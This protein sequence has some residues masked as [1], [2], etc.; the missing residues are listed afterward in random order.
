M[1]VLDQNPYT[2]PVVGNG[3]NKSYN[4]AFR[5]DYLTD[6]R[7]RVRKISDNTVTYY[8]TDFSATGLTVNG[9]LGVGGVVTFPIVA[10]AISNAYDVQIQRIVPYSQDVDINQQGGFSPDTIEKAIDRLVMQ[11]QQAY[12]LPAYSN[13]YLDQA[14]ASAA[15]AAASA[16]AINALYLLFDARVLGA[17]AAAPTLDNQGG[18]L[19]Q[20]AIYFNTVDL[21]TYIW[22]GAIWNAMGAVNSVAGRTGDVVLSTADVA[23]LDKKLKTIN[24]TIIGID[25]TNR[26][27]QSFISA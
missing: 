21:K 6:L 1:T 19:Q 15:S 17:K 20:G 26:A 16:A 13:S 25:M 27:L 2:T 4:Y 11:I 24:D 10:G 18:V 23:L 14:V 5:A 8:T 9:G 7:I 22:T 12:Q 3:V